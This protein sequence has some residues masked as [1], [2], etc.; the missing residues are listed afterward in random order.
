M[1]DS[2]NGTYTNKW[3]PRVE[4]KNKNVFVEEYYSSTDTEIYIDDEAQTEI[5]YISYSIQEQLKPLYGYSSR[6][7]DDVAVGNR[8]VSG[9]IKIPIRNPEIQTTL[10]EIKKDIKNP[11]NPNEEYNKE[12]AEKENAVEWIT[13]NTGGNSITKEYE[14][15]NEVFE[16]SEKL[17]SLGFKYKDKTNPGAS[18]TEQV[19]AFQASIGNTS[20]NG[21]LTESIK[22][23]I[24]EAIMK[25]SNLKKITLPEGAKIYNGPTELNDVITV[26]K[27][28]TQASIIDEDYDDGWKHIM[29]PNGVEGY[30]HIK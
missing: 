25:S 14:T 30:V 13:G 18:I 21:I 10:K 23:A 5:G 6:T 17:N 26:L 27:S 16:Y 3:I 7:F 20:G 22:N 28:E 4:Q 11:G 29:L 8:I 9:V 1:P 2:F 12:Q 19:K 24:D 15:S